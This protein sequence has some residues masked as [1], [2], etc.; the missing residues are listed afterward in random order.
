MTEEMKNKTLS[1]RAKQILSAIIDNYIEEG[2]PIGSKKLSSYNR[3]NLSPATV[4]FV[5]LSVCIQFCI[6]LLWGR[7]YWFSTV[8]V[9]WL[10]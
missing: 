6:D 4:K 9:L 7:E 5:V 1:D 2:T 3:F 8:I 10:V